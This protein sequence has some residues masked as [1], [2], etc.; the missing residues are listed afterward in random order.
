MATALFLALFAGYAL[1]AYPTLAP[2]D[3][4]DM[5]TAALTLG[6]AHPPGYPLYAALGRLWLAAIPW[7]DPAYRLNLLSAAAAAAAAALFFRSL[8]PRV[9]IAAALGGA[10]AWA[11][12]YPLWKFAGLAEKYAL[13]ALFAALLL[14]AARGERRS[15]RRRAVVS[16]LLFGLGLVNHP[17]LVL[18]IPALLWL[19]LA[20]RRR[21]EVAVRTLLLPT[22]GFAGLG[23]SLSI[24]VALRLGDAAFAWRVLTRAEYGSLELFAGLGG[25]MSPGRFYTLL[26]HFGAGLFDAIGLPALA[27]ALLGTW[28]LRQARSAELAVAV[29][30]IAGGAAFVLYS[31]F[32]PSNWVAR[33]VLEPAF[34]PP[35]LGVAL[36]ATHGL[37]ALNRWAPAA[38]LLLVGFPLCAHTPRL[39][40]RGDYAAYDYL[41]D[42]ERSLPPDAPAV[43][44]GDT[45]L[46]G[47]RW[48]HAL[49]GHRRNEIISSLEDNIPAW[50]AARAGRG[51][52][53]VTG[54]PAGG[55][56]AIGLEPARVAPQG[57]IQ[58]W[59]M[60]AA[61]PEPW[62]FY[63]LRTSAPFL[64]GES[65]AHDV[66]L[67][68]AFARYLSS[69]LS[70]ARGREAEAATH[71]RWAAALDPEDYRVE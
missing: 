65:Y 36:L 67:S 28:R 7:G 37:A 19:W 47:L 12:S 39:N 44:A 55:L 53:Y 18:V 6:V 52:V 66:R 24:F 29:L 1:T 42:L 35:A 10:L 33:S 57:L 31:R 11:A 70:A 54:L 59:G 38:L 68:Y 69:E 3:A 64:A 8:R 60:P 30:L 62:R 13:H 49:R 32:D 22:L 15:L 40:R 46:F 71:A 51:P 4:A 14:T 25:P 26:R 50:V 20:E 61:H 23:L 9:G 2:R 34:L 21:H 56:Q 41:R 16:G 5:A 58:R 45:A 63:G 43:I 48:R 17:T 27:L